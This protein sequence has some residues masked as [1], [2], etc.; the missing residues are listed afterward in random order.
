MLNEI[1][2][3]SLANRIVDGEIQA[4]LDTHL[5]LLMAQTSD[6]SPERKIVDQ[7]RHLHLAEFAVQLTPRILDALRRAGLLVSAP[8]PSTCCGGDRPGVDTP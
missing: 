7:A 2:D 5:G 1:H 6:D 3:L 8:E 4:W